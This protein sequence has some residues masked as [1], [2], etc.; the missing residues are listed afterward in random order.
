MVVTVGGM[1]GWFAG[2]KRGVVVVVLGRAL[3]GL[4]LGLG[5]GFESKAL[6]GAPGL[7]VLS[8]VVAGL[9]GGWL[10]VVII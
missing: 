7:S 10:M 5:L 6:G 1:G 3:G 2:V 4:G 8:D 9:G